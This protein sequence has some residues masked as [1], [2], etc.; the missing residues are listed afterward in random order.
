MH[1]NKHTSMQTHNPSPPPPV[2]LAVTLT[3]RI[4]I[5]KMALWDWPI[6]K[7]EMQFL[8]YWLMWEVQVT[9]VLGA[10]R[11]QAEQAM[12][13]K[14]VNSTSPRPLHHFQPPGFYSIWVPI[15]FPL[16]IDCC[17]TTNRNKSFPPQ[18]A[19]VMVIYHR[20]ESTTKHLLELQSGL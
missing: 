20:K 1:T 13:S 4:S 10:L 15:L 3:K 9:V 18:V 17:G 8:N 7:P 14:T 16:V 12:E 11:K 5:D 6:G 2:T 19:L